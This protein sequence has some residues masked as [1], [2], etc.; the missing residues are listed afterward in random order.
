[1]PA[2]LYAESENLAGVRVGNEIKLLYLHGKGS[3]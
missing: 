2:G 1:M 3:V